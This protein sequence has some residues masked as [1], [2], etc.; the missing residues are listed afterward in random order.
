MLMSGHAVLPGE[1]GL[2]VSNIFIP[3][4][5]P[6][7]QQ[8]K[9]VFVLIHFPWVTQCLGTRRFQLRFCATAHIQIG[10][11]SFINELSGRLL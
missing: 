10:Q 6:P 3:L 7:P 4:P 8:D 9:V 11:L 1:F 5:P 2:Q